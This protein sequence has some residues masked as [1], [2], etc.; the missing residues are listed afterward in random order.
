MTGELGYS[1]P[2]RGRDFSLF[3]GV[4]SNLIQ[5]VAVALSRHI[6]QLRHV[7]DHSSPS[8][9]EAKNVLSS[10]YI[11]NFSWRRQICSCRQNTDLQTGVRMTV[12]SPLQ[13]ELIFLKLCHLSTCSHSL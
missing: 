7:A 3:Y 6:K 8:C 5:W 11:V 4:E 12:S 9:D 1:I 10:S 13:S 2:S